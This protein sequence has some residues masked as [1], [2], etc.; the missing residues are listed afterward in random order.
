MYFIY[1]MNNNIFIL[2]YHIERSNKNKISDNMYTV[3]ELCLMYLCYDFI[4]CIFFFFLLNM[5]IY[6]LR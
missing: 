1:L 5:L 6:N 2:N 4:L 3:K